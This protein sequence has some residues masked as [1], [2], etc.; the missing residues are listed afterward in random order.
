MRTTTILALVLSGL[1]AL[2]LAALGQTVIALGWILLAT[3]ALLSIADDGRPATKTLISSSLG[4]VGLFIFTARY[5]LA[6][7]KGGSVLEAFRVVAHAIHL[8]IFVFLAG[9]YL[10]VNTF[11]YSGFIGD[12]AW[13]IVRRARGSLGPIM[14]AIMVLT[15]LLSGIFDGATVAS[16]MGIITLTILLSSGMQTRHI[17]QILL[18]L[19]VATNIGGVW[20]VL[21]EPTNILAAEKLDLSPFFFLRYASIFA[22]PAMAL[23]A[24]AAW[25]VVRSYP[26]IKDVRPEMEVLLEGVS[27]RRAHSGSASLVDSLK[28]IGTVE[29][30]S[31]VE[32][33]RI[34]EEEGLPDFEAALKAGIPQKKVHAALSINLNSEELARGLIDFYYYRSEGD[35]LADL[36]LGDLLLVVRDEYQA[37]TGSRRLI[38]ASGVVLIGLLVAH[39][40][41]PWMPTWAS[42]VI[43]GLLAIGAVKPKARRY[44]LAQT[45]ANLEEALFLAAIFVTIFELNYAG[46]F[47]ILGKGLLHGNSPA[48]TG[49][50]ILTGSALFS[51]V[52]D[53][54]AVM[55]VLTNLVVHH[56]QWSFFALASLVGTALGGFVSPIASVQ[57]V[58]MAS[59]IR[60]VSRVSFG[61]W[62]GVTLPWFLALLG[63]SLLLLFAFR[64]LGLPPLMALPGAGPMPAAGGH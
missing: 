53:N 13:R 44:I 41:L 24:W 37:R 10:V 38:L 34:I 14:V 61:R 35:P 6:A 8:E 45:G 32:M 42:T 16:I 40:F 22:L 36:V 9:L 52:A 58:I 56:E 62:L 26:R 28:S 57:A 43:A 15:C 7:A 39:A 20:F 33:E 21:G 31:L 51:A 3:M 50:A 5:G 64:A 2:A 54:V 59:I 46:A 30:R 60:R 12:L 19:V 27:L 1:A 55:D 18:L 25:R 63:A 49:A 11:A 23:A 47:E 4:L 29:V 17:V 48:A